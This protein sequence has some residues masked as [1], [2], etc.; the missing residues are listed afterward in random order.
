MVARI[1]QHHAPAGVVRALRPVYAFD[2]TKLVEGIDLADLQRPDHVSAAIDQRRRLARLQRSG[3]VPI[4][5]KGE[6]DGP[7][8]VLAV[9]D[10]H[11]AV[12]DA[13]P[14]RSVHR[15]AQRTEP[16]I[17]ETVQRRKVRL[18]D[19][20]LLQA[21]GASAEG[22]LFGSGHLAVNGLG[23]PAMWGDEVWHSG[24]SV[25]GRMKNP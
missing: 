21:G 10:D 15:P 16:A 1:V 25:G 12:E 5:R 17:A 4:D 18:A 3:K 2:I 23:D 20:D 24:D 14:G 9:V 8:V 11:L 7:G 22:A 6:G 13:V 19:G